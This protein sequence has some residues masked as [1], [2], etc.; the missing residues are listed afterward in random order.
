MHIVYKVLGGRLCMKKKEGTLKSKK[1]KLLLL[2]KQFEKKR[3][4]TVHTFASEA[5]RIYLKKPSLF[6]YDKEQ[7]LIFF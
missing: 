5:A 6:T 4:T 3:A 7:P 2:K 1:I